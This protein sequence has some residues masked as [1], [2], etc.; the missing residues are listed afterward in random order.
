M[1]NLG[2]KA[3]MAANIKKY[4][5]LTGKSQKDVCKELGFKESTFSDWLNAKV[6]PRIDKI[7][8]MANYF[9]IK[10]ADLV[11]DSSSNTFIK[12]TDAES[13]HIKNYRELSADDKEE[14]DNII[15]F[16]LEKVKVKSKITRSHNVIL[17]DPD[18]DENQPLTIIKDTNE[19]QHLRRTGS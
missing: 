15:N 9:G 5:E 6:Y 3:I 4:L 12:L 8:I 11:E 2:N 18:A 16:K 14:I 13:E 17:F 7:E 19:L 1:N 10:K